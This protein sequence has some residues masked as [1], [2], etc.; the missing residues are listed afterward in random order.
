MNLVFYIAAVLGAVAV[1]LTMP[2]G[3]MP[4]R[5]GVIGALLGVATLGGV[6]AWLAGITEDGFPGWY[7]YIFTFIAVASA[8]RVITHRRPV[9][10][11]LYFVLLV[12][13]S[14]GLLVILEA[15][16][17]AFAMVIIYAG[18]ILVTYVF[19]IMLATLP[20]SADRPETGAAYDN[21]AR[22]PLLAAAM[23][24]ALLGV[25]GNV[26]FVPGEGQIG[27]PVPRQSEPEAEALL[28]RDAAMLSGKLNLENPAQRVRLQKE[29]RNRDLISENEF[30]HE[31]EQRQTERGPRIMAGI[32]EGETFQA[33]RG[34]RIARWEAIP[35]PV[36]AEFVTNIDRVGLNLFEAHTLG[37]ELAGVILLL[38]MVGA[39]VIARRYAPERMP[40]AERTG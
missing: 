4:G 5:T 38:A 16:F 31:V 10:S 1:Y 8:V 23:G 13:A 21:R 17:M 35:A 6:L 11:A 29:M 7:Y 25:L 19:V 3:Q 12:L 37:I 9:Y 24:F 27:T 14:A 28:R 40:E 30:V 39:I 33:S 36:L 18:A 22:E 20:Q 2:R 34:A 32:R 26:L 15:E